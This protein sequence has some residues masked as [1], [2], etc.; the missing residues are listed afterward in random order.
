MVQFL[1]YWPLLLILL[2]VGYKMLST[3]QF[4]TQLPMLLTQNAQIIDVRTKQEFESGNDPRSINIPLDQFANYINDIKKDVPVI[5]V[6]RSGARSGSAAMMLQR[7]GYNNVY[8][9]GDWRNLAA[10]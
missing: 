5:I 1:D 6:C 9:G 2:F 7:L 10:H 8:N 4:K 3:Q